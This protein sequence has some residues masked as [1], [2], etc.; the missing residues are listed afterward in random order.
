MCQMQ[1]EY[2]PYNRMASLHKYK[3]TKYDDRLKVCDSF[4]HERENKIID[5]IGLGPKMQTY[6]RRAKNGMES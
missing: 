2:K 4:V 3:K 6:L 1:S 5:V